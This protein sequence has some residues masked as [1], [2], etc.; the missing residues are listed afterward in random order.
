MGNVE[1]SSYKLS[2][3]EKRLYKNEYTYMHTKVRGITVPVSPLTVPS[4]HP[5]GTYLFDFEFE[6]INTLCSSPY[7]QFWNYVDRV[8]IVRFVL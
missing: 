8:I 2:T 6:V 3:L 7:D 4:R 1:V 5:Q